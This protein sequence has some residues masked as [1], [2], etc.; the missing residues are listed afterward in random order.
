MKSLG[1]FDDL[2]SGERLQNELEIS[3][4]VHRKTANFRL[5]QFQE[6]T[7][8]ITLEGIETNENT[9]EP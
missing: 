7:V 8:K 3:T 2:A 6:Q 1:I 4:I 9:S 5:G